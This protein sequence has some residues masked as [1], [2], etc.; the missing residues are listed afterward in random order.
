MTRP[1]SAS[2]REDGFGLSFVKGVIE[3]HQGRV[4]AES[5]G[6]G[7]GSTFYMELPVK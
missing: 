4:W 3:A 1:N 5:E 7:Q 2:R 6:P